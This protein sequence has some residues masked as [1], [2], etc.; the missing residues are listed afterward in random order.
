MA[1]ILFKCMI[2]LYEIV[3]GKS[4]NCFEHQVFI[5]STRILKY[6]MSQIE[7]FGTFVQNWANQTYINEPTNQNFKMLAVVPMAVVFSE[8]RLLVA[9]V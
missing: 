3:I 8:S 7:S 1:L 4:H 2:I 9:T 5:Y 6:S